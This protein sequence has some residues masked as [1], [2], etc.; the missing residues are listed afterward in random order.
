MD[1]DLEPQ[2]LG[3]TSNEILNQSLS[4]ARARETLDWTP[5]W[6][7]DDS[8]RETIEWYREFLGE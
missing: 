8:L 5:Q 3:E 1:S 6:D 2:V 7:L 4:A